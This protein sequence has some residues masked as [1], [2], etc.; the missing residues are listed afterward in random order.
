MGKKRRDYIK[1]E[2]F[3]LQ[4]LL[5]AEKQ[6][7]TEG[8]TSCFLKLSTVR[9][10][11][12]RAD[13]ALRFCMKADSVNSLNGTHFYEEDFI[14]NK[15][16]VYAIKGDLDKALGMFN[17]S[18]SLALRSK[19]VLDQ[20]LA[21]QNIG[22]VYKEKGNYKKAY[23]YLNSGLELAKRNG[24][25][26]QELRLAINIPITL[27]AEKKYIPAEG[28]LLAL[29]LDA[30][31]LGL[32]D[33]TLE[34][35]QNLTDLAK[36]QGNYK[37]AL[38][39]FSDFA[40]LKDKQINEQ[41]GKALQEANISLGLYKANQKLAENENLLFQKNRERNV[42]FGILF[43]VAVLLGF[44]VFILMRLK[45]LNCRL[46]IKREQLTESNNI[47]NKLFSIIGHDLRS[48][49]STTLGI[50]NLIK[51]GE[52]DEKELKVYLDMII[53][54][55]QSA[56]ATLDDLL[57]WGQAQIKGNTLEMSTH[58]VLPIIKRAI[59]LN[60]EAIRE[61]KLHFKTVDLRGIEIIAY[62]SHLSFI[63]RNLIA[64]AIKFTPN[65]GNIV[66]YS[67]EYT[68]DLLK[69]CVADDGVG[70]SKNEL[71]TIFSPENVSKRGTNNESGTGLGLILCKE[72]VEANGGK[73]W[74]EGNT[75]GGT[76]ICFTCKKGL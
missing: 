73:I 14:G 70:M 76:T 30:K 66:I 5:L 45:R 67:E 31:A 24:L 12:N 42:I 55:S 13:D 47:K 62:G 25:R 60:A 20:V 44:L 27:I 17:Q 54:Q 43:F 46:N 9:I 48:H 16:I 6:G 64:N 38:S 19:K 63:I 69:L 74:A 75:N 56:L 28:K 36:M 11:Q 26:E 29:L 59:D 32:K 37:M 22:L 8:I 4:A 72:F 58:A 57:L 3:F 2:S 33:L 40:N 71:V 15:A 34:I 50:L 41:K 7:Y 39:Y 35:Y 10:K 68:T 1:A 65:E 52:L 23:Q 21:F 53:K 61:K 49:Q 18:Y 51:E